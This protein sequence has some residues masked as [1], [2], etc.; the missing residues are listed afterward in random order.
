MA[1]VR[2]PG[3]EYYEKSGRIKPLPGAYQRR[4]A[5]KERRQPG[6][7]RTEAR[8]KVSALQIEA[9]ATEKSHIPKGIDANEY[10]AAVNGMIHNLHGNREDLR[11]LRKTLQE[12]VEI[13]ALDKKD[14]MQSKRGRELWESKEDWMPP[15]IFYYN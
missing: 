7:S 10:R 9:Y 13:R 5:S 3:R 6:V 11:K 2:I 15:E 4:I 8:G 12:A 1:H 14:P